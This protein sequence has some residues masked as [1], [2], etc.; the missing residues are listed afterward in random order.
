MAAVW[1]WARSEWRRRRAALVGLAVLIALAGGTTLAAAGGARRADSAIDRWQAGTNAADVLVANDLDRILVDP[2]DLR[3]MVAELPTAVELADE[4]AAVP[5]V[6][7]VRVHAYVA[8]SPAPGADFF[9]FGFGAERGE[10]PR[11]EFVSGRAP[12]PAA[13]DEVVVNEA[14]E[15]VWGVHVG[16]SLTVATLG[17]G[18]W[19]VFFRF[20]SG[21]PEGPTMELR[22]VGVM[23]EIESIA[24]RPE[25]MAEVTPAFLARW[26]DQVPN[27]VGGASV[28]VDPRRLEEVIGALDGVGG[29]SYRAGRVVDSDDFESRIRDTIDVEVTALWAFGGA[30]G[31]AG[32]LIVVQALMRH[33]A[34]DADTRRTRRAL[35][36][37]PLQQ[38]GGSLVAVAPALVAGF[39]GALVVAVAAS[40]LLPTGAARFAEIDPG[41]RVDVAL[42]LVGGVAF[43]A[44]L[45]GAW[46]AAAIVATPTS[47]M[48][49]QLT[50]SGRPAHLSR[51]LPMVPA[52]GARL[53]LSGR[54]RPT[55]GWIGLTAVAVAVTG[56]VAVGTVAVS[57]D[58]LLTTPALYGAP[59][60]LEMG[61]D[62]AEPDLY[63]RLAED[64]DVAMV[65]AVSELALD[66]GILRA[67]GPGREIDVVPHTFLVE[68]GPLPLVLREGRTPGPGEAA[69]GSEILDRVGARIGDDVVVKGH[70]GPVRLTI[71]G[72]TVNAGEDELDQGFYVDADTFESLRANCPPTARDQRCQVQTFGGGL[73]LRPDADRDAA[74]ARLQAIAPELQPTARP[75]VVHN[76]AEIGSAPVLLGGFLTLL[77]IAGLTHALLVSGQRSRRDLAVRRALGLRPG[78][79]AGVLRWEAATLTVLGAAIGLVA[80]V[81]V[82]RN[83][84]QRVADGVGAVV[85]TEIPMPLL[86]VAPV[87]AL[88]VAIAV[89]TIPAHRAAR[90]RPADVLRTE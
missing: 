12:D 7:G 26:G 86:I 2:E 53:A 59:W 49:R 36:V 51:A 55:T 33:T 64:P 1:L 18:Q 9:A 37:T 23:R 65:A 79:A 44:V 63:T 15:E 52:L 19:P 48:K 84:W 14:A 40:P 90:L 61:E 28:N 57:V 38:V 89:A 22:V 82:G 20:E 72:E 45:V 69:V 70:R 30:A 16:E 17:S 3:E 71:T 43:A 39:V 32:V 73:A 25:P 35:G 46:G 88:A 81:I 24:D 66:D 62:S 83:I 11:A 77:G 58:E 31:V 80:G 5:G 10:S 67:A 76:L 74:T 60:D 13:A 78:Q 68:R 54:P 41:V 47:A 4:I 8:M 29:G 27:L 87:S 34:A 42:L 6:R 56:V 21:S 85:K 50:R 75:S